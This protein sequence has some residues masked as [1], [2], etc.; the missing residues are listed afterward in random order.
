M[1]KSKR[2][3][4]AN[5]ESES[6]DDGMFPAGCRQKH[7]G[8]IPLVACKKDGH[9]NKSISKEESYAIQP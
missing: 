5:G 3:V 2:L 7:D 4:S 6:N 1:I 9:N 8:R